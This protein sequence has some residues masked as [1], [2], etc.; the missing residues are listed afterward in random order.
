MGWIVVLDVPLEGARA[1]DDRVWNWLVEEK[2]I[3][4]TA[5]AMPPSCGNELRSRAWAYKWDADQTFQARPSP[6][7]L[8]IAI[9]RRVFDAV[10]HGIDALVCPACETRH[11][12]DILPWSDA[13]GA[14]H[15]GDCVPSR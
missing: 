1:L 11:D 14:W 10:G 8:E 3:L 12:P 5:D 15:A 7:G 6:C 4:A 13:V 9:G 2:I